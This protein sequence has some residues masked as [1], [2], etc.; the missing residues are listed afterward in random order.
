LFRSIL[1]WF[2]SAP[3]NAAA[4]TIRKPVYECIPGNALIGAELSGK[5]G[6]RQRQAKEV[7]DESF[8]TTSEAHLLPAKNLSAWV[9]ANLYLSLADAPF[10]REDPTLNPAAGACAAAKPAIIVY[11]KRVGTTLT[12]CTDNHCPVHDPR[13]AA[14]L[15]QDPAPTMA[16]APEQETEE[17]AEERK[18]QYEQQQIE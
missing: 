6:S 7:V 9:Q 13:A 10:Y 14:R 8:V 12:V 5:S 18:Q 16:P 11:G 17:E 4:P 1:T 3:Y 15:A 2:L